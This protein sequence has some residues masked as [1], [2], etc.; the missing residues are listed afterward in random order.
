M[1]SD[2]SNLQLFSFEANP[3]LK[4]EHISPEA[5][6]TTTIFPEIDFSSLIA[7]FQDDQFYQGQNDI[8]DFSEM[9]S[10]LLESNLFTSLSND[11]EAT[12]PLELSD[13]KKEEE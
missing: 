3:S 4:A 13:G 11:A 9:D 6:P 10:S 12:K 8:F 1:K 7:N 2:S 5:S